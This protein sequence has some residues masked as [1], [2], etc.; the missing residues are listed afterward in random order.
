MRTKVEKPVCLG[1]QKGAKGGLIEGWVPHRNP[2]GSPIGAHNEILKTLE[3][4]DSRGGWNPE[5]GVLVL[6]NP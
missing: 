3:R 2:K 5:K 6:W 1:P 4:L